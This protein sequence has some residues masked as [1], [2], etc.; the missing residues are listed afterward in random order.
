MWLCGGNSA[1]N[2]GNSSTNLSGD[3]TITYKSDINGYRW[4]NTSGST[5]SYTFTTI[6]TNSN[7]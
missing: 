7:S 2:L 4:T 1:V 5:N 6:K 3:G